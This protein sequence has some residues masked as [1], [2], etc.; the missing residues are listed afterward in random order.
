MNILHSFYHLNRD[1]IQGNSDYCPE[2][3]HHLYFIAGY[4]CAGKSSY[5]DLL[6]SV[7]HAEP[8]VEVECEVVSVSKT[9]KL[10]AE[11]AGIDVE[12]RQGYDQTADLDTAIVGEINRV[13]DS[14]FTSEGDERV[15]IV[16]GPR[17]A[18]IVQ[19]VMDHVKERYGDVNTYHWWLN[20]PDGERVYRFG[21]RGSCKDQDMSLSEAD[22]VDRGLGIEEMKKMFFAP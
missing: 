22:R 10:L 15:V 17:Q 8:K 16:D 20:T 1:C 18:S 9:C 19:G 4:V 21:K 7:F 6:K 3:I 13:V 5:C 11:G 2:N 12:R 14:V